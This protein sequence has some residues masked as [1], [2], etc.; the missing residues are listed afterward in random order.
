M[1]GAFKCAWHLLMGFYCVPQAPIRS[2]FI[3]ASSLKLGN[4]F[5]D[6]MLQEPALS[7]RGQWWVIITPLNSSRIWLLLWQASSVHAPE[8]WMEFISFFL[9]A[10]QLT[11]HIW[12]SCYQIPQSKLQAPQVVEALQMGRLIFLTLHL[13]WFFRHSSF[14]GLYPNFEKWPEG[15]LLL[16]IINSVSKY[17]GSIDCLLWGSQN[18][19][20]KFKY[21]SNFLKQR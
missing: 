19:H 21:F 11:Q 7:R 10:S 1:S 18:T 4:G 3:F 17:T 16:A 9:A 14:L 12:E 5:K 20:F 2:C 8:C 13:S 15:W 6:S